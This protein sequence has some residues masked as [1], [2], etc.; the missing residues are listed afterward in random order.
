MGSCV[1]K[2][3]CR[4]K[5]FR[6]LQS[7]NKFEKSPRPLFFPPTC[8]WENQR[9]IAIVLLCDIYSE[10]EPDNWKPVISKQFIV[11]QYHR[12]YHLYLE[13]N[14]YMRENVCRFGTRY[15]LT[16]KFHLLIHIFEDA[17]GNPR[18]EWCYTDESEIGACAE[19]AG[20]LH[21]NSLQRTLLERY[22]VG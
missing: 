9:N 12:F 7:N 10:M 13:V 11:A 5:R 2:M 4:Q 6:E 18:D 16:P 21:A 22:R 8:E 20:N 3:F 19:M 1:Q 17:A 14:R 15:H